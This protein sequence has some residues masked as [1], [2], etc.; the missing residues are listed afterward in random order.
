MIVAQCAEGWLIVRQCLSGNVHNSFTIA[1]LLRTCKH[2][3]HTCSHCLRLGGPGKRPRQ[4]TYQAHLLGFLD[5]SSHVGSGS[6]WW[7]KQAFKN[8]I[9]VHICSAQRF[10][11]GNPRTRQQ[12]TWPIAPLQDAKGR[13][14][15]SHLL[16]VWSHQVHLEEPFPYKQQRKL[17]NEH[18]NL[19]GH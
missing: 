11:T 16:F 6:L 4:N 8:C 17:A 18:S 10:L 13:R 14:V 15:G 2:G 1:K 5:Q 9:F 12:N 3:C 7:W 19:F